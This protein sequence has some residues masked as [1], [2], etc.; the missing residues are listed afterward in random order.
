MDVRRANVKWHVVSIRSKVTKLANDLDITVE[1]NKIYLTISSSSFFKQR[2]ENILI[3]TTRDRSYKILKNMDT[4]S[5][6]TCIS[7]TH[8]TTIVYTNPLINLKSHLMF[9]IRFII[10]F[11]IDLFP[12]TTLITNCESLSMMILWRSFWVVITSTSWIA[13]HSA[14]KIEQSPIRFPSTIMVLAYIFLNIFNRGR[15]YNVSFERSIFILSNHLGAKSNW[16]RCFFVASLQVLAVRYDEANLT[17]T[18]NISL[19]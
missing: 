15:P 12:W 17:Q 10:S 1:C 13:K 2:K 9:S 7:V 8:S 16:P 6:S 14:T 11:G 5:H 4:S 19:H 18:Y 3:I